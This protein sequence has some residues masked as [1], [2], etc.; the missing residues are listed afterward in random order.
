MMEKIIQRQNENSNI[1]DR[2]I[3]G[4]KDPTNPGY[5]VQGL[6][7]CHN[8]GELRQDQMV[9]GSNNN[10]NKCGY[11]NELFSTHL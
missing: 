9:H 7:I 5:I 4:Y 2:H 11:D 8:C 6:Q 10:N 3:A 1:S